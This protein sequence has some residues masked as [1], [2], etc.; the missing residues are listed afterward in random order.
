MRLIPVDNR[1]FAA[2]PAFLSTV[3]TPPAPAAQSLCGSF[4]FT[5]DIPKADR[6]RNNK[7]SVR[8]TKF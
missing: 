2:V 8:R 5:T 6:G 7:Q 4:V 1:S 3:I